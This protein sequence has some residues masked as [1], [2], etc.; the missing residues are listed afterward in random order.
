MIA[1]RQKYFRRRVLR[2]HAPILRDHIVGIDVDLQ[3]AQQ[4]LGQLLPAEFEDARIVAVECA[5]LVACVADDHGD[6]RRRRR[7]GIERMPRQRHLIQ[8]R[9]EIQRPTSKRWIVRTRGSDQGSRI[10]RA[11]AFRIDLQRREIRLGTL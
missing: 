5:G 3:C 4:S 11:K 2:I 1:P 10:D 6:I 9:S 8:H 7:I